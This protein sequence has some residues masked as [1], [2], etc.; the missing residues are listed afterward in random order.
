MKFYAEDLVERIVGKRLVEYVG[1]RE[2]VN[3]ILLKL[4]TFFEL[5]KVKEE[6]D[7]KRVKVDRDL[8]EDIKDARTQMLKLKKIWEWKQRKDARYFTCAIDEISLLKTYFESFLSSGDAVRKETIQRL[9]AEGWLSLIEKVCSFDEREEKNNA[10]TIKGSA[11]IVSKDTL[12]LLVTGKYDV[13]YTTLYMNI[14]NIIYQKPLLTVLR[15]MDDGSLFEENIYKANGDEEKKLIELCVECSQK[16]LG[17]KDVRE[18]FNTFGFY[19]RKV[20][21]LTNDTDSIHKYIDDFFDCSVNSI[22]KYI[23]DVLLEFQ[24]LIEEKTIT[25]IKKIFSDNDPRWVLEKLKLS[26]S[27]IDRL[28]L[29]ILT[30]LIEI[31]NVV[32]DENWREIIDQ[33]I[34]RKFC[35]TVCP[36][37]ELASDYLGAELFSNIAK[38]LASFIGQ[39]KEKK[40]REEE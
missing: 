33:V 22:H 23:D 20:A 15:F 30:S 36:P 28:M 32:G 2:D 1:K 17:K 4:Q 11:D 38:I 27:R 29:N 14:L 31:Q 37:F 19:S 6:E 18:I 3:L 39:K 5:K 24:G 12:Y 9:Y 21:E 13:F 10:L 26:K 35:F 8:I 16:P 7:L 40:E 34:Y 25:F